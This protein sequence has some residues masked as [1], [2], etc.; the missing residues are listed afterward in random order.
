MARSM[1]IDMICYMADCVPYGCLKVG[2]K[3][4]LAINL[5]PMVGLTLAETEGCLKELLEAGVVKQMADG[6]LYS[7]RMMRDEEIRRKRAAGGHL[8]GNPEL[9]KGRKVNGNNNY[10]VNKEVVDK[11]ILS[12]EN[13]NNNETEDESVY[14]GGGAGGGGALM[15][16]KKFAYQYMNQPD[17]AESRWKCMEQNNLEPDAPDSLAIL[18]G[19]MDIFV[20]GETIAGNAIKTFAEWARHWRNWY[21]IAIGQARTP[22]EYKLK[23]QHNGA[24][25]GS[26][27]TASTGTVKIDP[28][29]TKW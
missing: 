5:A 8:G 11:V 27:G 21:G 4:I 10:K 7:E 25:H 15:G 28:N 16:C 17:Y 24:K 13:D 6:T 12:L 19:W 14:E 2:S 29:S 22:E 26:A 3:V 23:K 20:D 18:K 1:W 9:K